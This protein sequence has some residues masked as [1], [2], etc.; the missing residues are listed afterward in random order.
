MGDLTAEAVEQLE[1][2]VLGEDGLDGGGA[3]CADQLV[4]Q[5]G[6][7]AEE[8]QLF[9][10]V[11]RRGG[12]EQP[13]AAQAVTYSRFLADV[14]ETRQPGAQAARA[15]PVDEA[16]DRHRA[17]HRHDRHTFGRQIPAR[18]AGDAFDRCRSLIP[19]T[20]HDSPQGAPGQRLGGGIGERR[21]A[22]PRPS[23]LHDASLTGRVEARQAKRRA[24]YPRA[25]AGGGPTGAPAGAPGNGESRGRARLTSSSGQPG[26]QIDA[27]GGEGCRRRPASM[28]TSCP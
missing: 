16:A 9:Q 24:R 2:A 23:L 1:V 26:E 22:G 8:A 18:L 7:A 12:V 4:F 11:R 25:N 17:A 20:K 15:E 28:P 14:V 3:E 19:L 10:G 21:R 5:I 27:E 13:C 6:G